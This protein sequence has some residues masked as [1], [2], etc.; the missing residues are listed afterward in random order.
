MALTLWLGPGAG[1]GAA[2]GPGPVDRPEA[3]EEEEEEDGERDGAALLLLLVLLR[4]LLEA[5]R[6]GAASC[7]PTGRHALGLCG[8]VS[9]CTT[10][11]FPNQNQRSSFF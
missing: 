1:A 7:S 5:D 10:L 11:V 3:E 9:V 6:P 4:V 2:R 8:L